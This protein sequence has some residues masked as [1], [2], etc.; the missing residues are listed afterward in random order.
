MAEFTINSSAVGNELSQLLMVDDLTPGDEPSYQVCRS[1]YL[2]HPVGGRMVDSPIKLAQSQPRV[3]T[4]NEAPEEVADAFIEEWK[5]MKADE[6][7][8]NVAGVARIYGVGSLVLGAVD[9]PT[10]VPLDPKKFAD[11]ELYFNVVDPLNTAGSLV[12]NQNPN[13]PDFQKYTII[14]VSGQ[15]YHRSRTLVLMNEKPIYIAYTT[16]AFGYVGRSVYQRALYPLKTFVQSMITDDMVTTKAGLLIAKLQP[17]GSIVDKLM[18]GVAGLKRSMLKT[19]KTGNVLSIST[20]NAAG[21]GEES[22]ETLDMQNVDG[23]GGWARGNVLKNIATAADMPAILLENEGLSQGGGLGSE[24]SED[25]KMIA[26]YVGTIRKWMEPVYEF[27]QPIVQRRAWNVDFFHVMQNKY[28]DLYG[29]MTYETALYS[30]IND[31]KSHWPNFLEEPESE[32][33]K[34]SETKLKT[35]ISVVQVLLPEL[36]P[37]N[38]A[39]VLQWLVDNLNADDIMFTQALTLDPEALESFAQEQI[40]RASNRDVEGEKDETGSVSESY[41]DAAVIG[42]RVASL[43]RSRPRLALTQD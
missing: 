36:D 22:I 39:A 34:I 4:V 9:V 2:F 1:L 38:K 23:A 13:A 14:T 10:N 16:S 29:K 30:W 11:Y 8:A 33:I 6:I 18:A 5:K 42:G 31:F 40:D 17:A 15:P 26:N 3:V 32:K 25:A 20:G 35:L 27:L 19:A 43:I 12:L 41:A 37:M 7:A 28:P 21:I 24:G